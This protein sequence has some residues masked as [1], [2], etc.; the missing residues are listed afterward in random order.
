MFKVLVH[1]NPRFS[2]HKYYAD[3]AGGAG[4]FFLIRIDENNHV[5]YPINEIK[6][7]EITRVTEEREGER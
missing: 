3:G 4:N 5:Y 6:R 1:T 2:P 7:V